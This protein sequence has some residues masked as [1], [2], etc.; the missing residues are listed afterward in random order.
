MGQVKRLGRL[1]VIEPL[2]PARLAGVFAKSF[3][4]G[5]FA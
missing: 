5:D 1:P 4:Q 2:T 3:E